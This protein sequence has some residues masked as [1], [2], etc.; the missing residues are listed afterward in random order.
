ML[1]MLIYGI[2]SWPLL[3]YIT[4][5]WAVML[6]RAGFAFVFYV[7]YRNK[8]DPNRY[9]VWARI[10]RKIFPDDSV[11]GQVTAVYPSPDRRQH[12]V[13]LIVTVTPGADAGEFARALDSVTKSLRRSGVDYE[14]LIVID[15]VDDPQE[16]LPPEP[17]V[18]RKLTGAQRIFVV[19]KR[20]AD[21][22]WTHAN[23]SKRLGL[24]HAISEARYPILG[25]MDDDTVSEPETV[26]EALRFFH[27]RQVG[28]VTTAQRVWKPETVMQKLA[29][30]LE[31]ARLYASMAAMS[32]FGQVGCLPGR[33][34]FARKELIVLRLSQFVNDYARWPRRVLRKPGDD[35]WLTMAIMRSGHWTILAPDARVWTLAPATLRETI[36]QQRRWAVSSQWYTLESLG[37]L[38]RYPM[39]FFVYVADIFVITLG[40]VAMLVWWAY[41]VYVG[42]MK[43]SLAAMLAVAIVGMS[44]TVC[45]RQLPHLRRNWRRDWKLVPLFALYA[46]FLQL[47]ARLRALIWPVWDKWQTRAVDG[48][49]GEK[50]NFVYVYKKQ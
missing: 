6:P 10:F 15:A 49:A 2:T 23:R 34:Y 36:P 33:L 22:V 8:R 37:W 29:D 27:N 31:N 32:L 35:R 30:W 50:K 40:T 18:V 13:S 16:L 25:L 26:R 11:A 14:I 38:W 42:D 45:V 9:P 21:R 4:A 5:V 19:A 28:G 43:Q 47:D 1:H 41:S 17:G 12:A 44:L 20:Y 46:L 48:G 39:T 24:A 7:L 3:I